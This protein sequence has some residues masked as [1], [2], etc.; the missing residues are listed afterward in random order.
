MLTLNNSLF[1]RRPS[2]YEN[3]IA[4]CDFT[5][6]YADTIR[7]GVLYNSICLNSSL[8]QNFRVALAFFD[9]VFRILAPMMK[10]MPNQS[11]LAQLLA[12]AG[13]LG[14]CCCDVRV[15]AG[16]SAQPPSVTG[17]NSPPPGDA[18]KPSA[19]D[20]MAGLDWSATKQSFLDEKGA[21]VLSGSAY[22]RYSGVKLE[23]D[24]IVFYRETREMYAEGIRDGQ[25]EA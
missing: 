6:D 11:I 3:E 21:V 1:Q 18:G 24:N 10:P 4:F 2:A 12:L 23:A 9:K 16:E 19:S 5:C 17:P 8:I 25:S 15:T 14:I 20:M 7:R 13:L 22:V